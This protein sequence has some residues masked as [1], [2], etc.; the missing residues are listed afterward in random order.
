MTS[1]LG[2]GPANFLYS[3]PKNVA[4]VGTKTGIQS[5]CQRSLGKMAGEET[6]CPHGERE[7]FYTTIETKHG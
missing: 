6:R 7:K 2:V 1:L 3:W 4:F 5:W